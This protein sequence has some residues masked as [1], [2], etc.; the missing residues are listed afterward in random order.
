MF[1]CLETKEPKVQ[2]L[3]LSAKNKICSLKILKLARIQMLVFQFNIVSRSNSRIFLTFT[4]FIFLTLRFPRSFN[5]K[6]VY[7]FN[8]CVIWITVE[9]FS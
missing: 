4:D 9:Y 7:N 5:I 6:T 2:D 3:E 1:F 8:Y